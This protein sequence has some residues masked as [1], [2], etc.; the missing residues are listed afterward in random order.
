MSTIDKNG[1]KVNSTLFDFINKEVIPKTGVKSDDFWNNFEKV[2]HELTP[3]NKNL[4]Q[5]RENIQKKI[6][7][8]HKDKKGKDLDKKEYTE[9]LKS[10]SYIVEEKQDFNIKTSNVDEEIASIAGPQLVVPGR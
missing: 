10:I 2:V 4:I 3:L 7:E 1:L 8:W 9:F 6:D 5:K